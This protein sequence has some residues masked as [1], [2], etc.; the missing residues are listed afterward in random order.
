MTSLAE[1]TAT[2]HNEIYDCLL[3]KLFTIAYNTFNLMNEQGKIIFN[4]LGLTSALTP[5]FIHSSLLLLSLLFAS[6]ISL[7][8][9][10]DRDLLLILVQEPSFSSNLQD[11]PG[12][13]YNGIK[14]W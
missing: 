6:M 14:A 5:H 8:S 1:V 7:L 12:E 11:I 2:E 4:F 9:Q 3:H 13:S 10:I